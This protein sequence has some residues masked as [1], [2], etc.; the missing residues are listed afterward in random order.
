MR[1]YRVM[2]L[3][4]EVLNKQLTTQLSPG[5]DLN[6][7]MRTS[8]TRASQQNL[9]SVLSALSISGV[10]SINLYQQPHRPSTESPLLTGVGPLDSCLRVNQQ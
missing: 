7:V 9:E 6:H 1:L 2:C 8:R 4:L 5:R 3:N 10:V